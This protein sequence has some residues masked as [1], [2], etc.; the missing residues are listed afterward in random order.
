MLVAPLTF[1]VP[2]LALW[3]ALS[4]LLVFFLYRLLV[5]ERR[6]KTAAPKRGNV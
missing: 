1:I 4:G 3:A 2:L 5:G 6:P